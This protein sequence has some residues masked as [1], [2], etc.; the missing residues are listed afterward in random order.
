MPGR[1][2]LGKGGCSVGGQIPWDHLQPASFG[3]GCFV[4]HLCSHQEGSRAPRIPF[5]APAQPGSRFPVGMGAGCWEGNQLHPAPGWI[6][7]PCHSL[8]EH[9][10][11]LHQ[12]LEQEVPAGLKS[13]H[14]DPAGWE[15][16]GNRRET[17]KKWE[18]GLG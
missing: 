12:P 6:S 13:P 9:R 7:D 8:L 10:H 4:S 3:G 18:V 11:V 1:R 2:D 15:R 17:G 16:S 5:L 14:Q